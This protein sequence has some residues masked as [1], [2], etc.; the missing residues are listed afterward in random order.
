[1]KKIC[2]EYI[3]PGMILAQDIK[4]IDGN[5]LLPAGTTI[6]DREKNLLLEAGIDYVEVKARDEAEKENY[7]EMV[8]QEY[9]F[10]FFMYVNPDSELFGELYK[11]VVELLVNSLKRGWVLP[12]EESLRAKNVERMKDLFLKDMG[13]PED[14]IKHEVSLASFPDVYF[15]L[16]KVL[17]SKTASAKEIA[18][19][20]SADVALSAKLLKLVNSPLFGL[21]Q[22]IDSIERAVSII[23][24][25]ELSNLALGITAIRY[26]KDIPPELIDMNT[27]WKH[28]LSCAVFAK[29]LSSLLKIPNEE[30]MFTCGLLHDVG[31]LILFKNL[32]YGSVEALIFARENMIPVVEAEENV[33]G[34]THTHISNLIMKQWEFPPS[35]IDIVSHHHN[36][37]GAEHF[38]E[39]AILQVADNMANAISI[40]GGGMFVVPG[41]EEDVWKGLGL[42]VELISQIVAKHNQ[43]LK[44][45]LSAIL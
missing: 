4:G 43:V 2:V 14:V 32:P 12:C 5:V 13:G 33:L 10:K 17:E 20:V 15:K 19:V 39:A 6:R 24:E 16:K 36:P 27:F 18:Q 40:A 42:K 38:K 45:L 7:I 41:M 9:A 8:A 1:V 29:I 37:Q 22:K 35:L 25:Q 26:F 3:M 31:K 34:F 23:G 30:F 44:G 21:T 28:S 11:L